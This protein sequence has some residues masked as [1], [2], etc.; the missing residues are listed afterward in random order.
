MPLQK[1]FPALRAVFR[2]SLLASAQPF[3]PVVAHGGLERVTDGEVVTQGDGHAVGG[4]ETPQRPFDRECPA[5]DMLLK[6]F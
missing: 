4:I 6:L 3:D 5:D 1:L 2:G